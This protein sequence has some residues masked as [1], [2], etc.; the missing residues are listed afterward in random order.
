MQTV[1]DLIRQVRFNVQEANKSAVSDETIL[2]ALNRAKNNS[3]DIMAKHYPEAL[4]ETYTETTSSQAIDI[5]ER[6]FQDRVVKVERKEQGTGRWVAVKRV[7]YR[8][9]GNLASNNTSQYPVVWALSQRKINFPAPIN[10]TE[11]RV[12]YIKDIGKL[13]KQQGRIDVVAS[14]VNNPAHGPD[15]TVDVANGPYITV[16]SVGSDVDPS[17]TYNKYVS[18]IDSST[19]EVKV[20]MQAESI[21]GAQVKFKATPTRT[22]VINMPVSS[23][24]SLNLTG[25]AVVVEL[26]DYICILGGTCVVYF[27]E[28]LVNYI[29]QY[30]TNEIRDSLGTLKSG[31][32]NKLDKKEKNI[33]NT[34]S[35]RESTKRMRNRSPI[36]NGGGSS[37]RRRFN[38]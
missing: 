9:L 34:Y 8:D 30:A 24:T 23:N 36:W 29:I 13:V 31:Q 15:I 5:P 12:W 35:G 22:S 28:P 20:S 27:E 16:D 10:S 26:D 11:V 17:N 1:D 21:T 25:D 32:E 4:L 3:Y 7:T 19:G 37:I 38:K 18:V 14:S 33:A 6:A 2:D